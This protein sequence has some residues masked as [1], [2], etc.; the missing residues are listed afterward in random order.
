MDSIAKAMT[1]RDA[2]F[3]SHLTYVKNIKCCRTDVLTLD[4]ENVYSEKAK[5]ERP[6][7]YVTQSK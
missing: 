1:K 6:T 7:D 4:L 5:G 2:Y 3:M